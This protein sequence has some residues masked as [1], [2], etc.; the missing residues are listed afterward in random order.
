MSG[1][2]TTG[3]AMGIEYRSALLYAVIILV[4]QLTFFNHCHEGGAEEGPEAKELFKSIYPEAG[5]WLLED[6]PEVRMTLDIS[7]EELGNHT[8]SYAFQ[9]VG[10]FEWE[11]IWE[12]N[13]QL[14]ENGTFVDMVVPVKL[15][16]GQDNWIMFRAVNGSGNETR[17]EPFNLLLDTEI[18]I[19]HLVSH[20][21]DE[22]YLDPEQEVRIQIDDRASGVLASSI[23]YRVTT[24]GLS[25]WSHWMA[26]EDAGFD[27]S[28]ITATIVEQ[29]TRGD[30]NFLQVRAKDVAGNP[31]ATSNAYNIKINTLPII[32][33]ISPLPGDVLTYDQDIVF[34]AEGSYD[35]DG[36]RIIFQWFY[37]DGFRTDCLGDAQKVRVRMDAGEYKITLKVKDRVNN[38]VEE[39]FNII[40]EG[41]VPPP[42]TDGDGMPDE[43]EE[44]YALVD[45]QANDSES[46][47]DSD[48]LTNI[49]E[50]Q[51]GTNPEE[52]DTDEDGIPDG[53]EYDN[54]IDP[55]D[56]EDAG[57]DHDLDGIITLYEYRNGTDPWEGGTPVNP[58]PPSGDHEDRWYEKGWFWGL[59]TLVIILLV[60]L[61]FWI[62]IVMVTREKK[63]D[64][65]KLD[66]TISE[67]K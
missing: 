37:D 29:L 52:E 9:T 48:G 10:P 64:L 23:E 53:W 59:A 46:D 22:Y 8:L 3:R 25:N 39:H 27:D 15:K 40:V 50:Y 47:P 51:L 54:F 67:E 1:P 20:S 36:D 4:G 43:W 18:P 7:L 5:I 49:M 24:S 16:E 30:K 28:K 55:L 57:M 17:S 13:Y 38:E 62:T 56:P 11:P 35:P 61:A 14:E 44:R 42:D 45:S 34:D 12:S 65:R 66:E 58:L 2:L 32:N 33:I 26:Y 21:M 6:R 63:T 19:F 60:F 31:V 41:Y